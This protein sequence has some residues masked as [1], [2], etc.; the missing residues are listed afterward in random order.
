M[1]KWL[2]RSL[3]VDYGNCLL[4]VIR[5]NI[6]QMEKYKTRNPGEQIR[7]K[8]QDEANAILAQYSS[9]KNP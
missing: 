5:M 4:V 7:N 3:L 8:Y 9:V 2:D 6:L 1:E